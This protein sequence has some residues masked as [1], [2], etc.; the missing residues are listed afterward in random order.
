MALKNREVLLEQ[1]VN[2]GGIRQYCILHIATV[3]IGHIS[4]KVSRREIIE[5]ERCSLRRRVYDRSRSPVGCLLILRTLGIIEFWSNTNNRASGNK[6]KSLMGIWKR[7]S[8]NRP[9][10]HRV[11]LFA[12]ILFSMTFPLF[13]FLMT[14]F[15]PFFFECFSTLFY[16]R[17]LSFLEGSTLLHLHRRCIPPCP[18]WCTRNSDAYIYIDARIYIYTHI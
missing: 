10:N 15:R 6:K 7:L 2:P 9:S 8:V 4:R 1:N 14:L 18:L 17:N 11:V 3:F 12:Y 16:F 5:S 13:F